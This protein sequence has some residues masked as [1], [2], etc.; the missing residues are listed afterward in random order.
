MDVL[1]GNSLAKQGKM[2]FMGEVE[3][4]GTPSLEFVSPMPSEWM[5]LE[6]R[7]GSGRQGRLALS[8]C[9]ARTTLAAG[10]QAARE[11]RLFV[12]ESL[13]SWGITSSSDTMETARLLASEMVTN[14]VIHSDSLAVFVN[15]SAIGETVSIGV[16]D[17]GRS[18]QGIRD[19]APG[20]M[21][22]G[23]R[24]IALVKHLSTRWG[25]QDYQFGRHVW[26]EFVLP[27]DTA[28]DIG[29]GLLS[30]TTL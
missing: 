17:Y 9:E 26:A 1:H 3:F 18:G 20:L 10:P 14:A 25:H 11:A 8:K 15:V 6:R 4:T 7:N 24:G 27:P 13:T 30:E 12:Q 19:R 23:G 28:P 29:H 22:E 2:I 16:A 21:D 5:V